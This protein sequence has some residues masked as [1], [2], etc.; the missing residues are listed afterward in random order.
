MINN[1][2]THFTMMKYFL[3]KSNFRYG[4]GLTIGAIF[5]LLS[6]SVFADAGICSYSGSVCIGAKYS[7]G[8]QPPNYIFSNALDAALEYASRYNRNSAKNERWELKA[9]SVSEY[10]GIYQLTLLRFALSGG[11]WSLPEEHG[12]SAGAICDGGNGP[13]TL[14][15]GVNKCVVRVVDVDHRQPPCNACS[16]GRGNSIY[17]LTGD[18]RQPVETNL[19]LGFQSLRQLTSPL[20]FRGIHIIT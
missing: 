11:Q 10:Y 15:M 1:G 5:V 18:K 16:V 3:V 12:F 7:D 14:F 2:R 6:F 8:N 9:G 4:V 17:P 19:R 20:D 13:L